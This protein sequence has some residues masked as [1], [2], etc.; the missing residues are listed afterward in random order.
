M[1]YVPQGIESVFKILNAFVT[2]K[3]SLPRAMFKF[4]YSNN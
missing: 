4:F 1:Y 3:M 2:L